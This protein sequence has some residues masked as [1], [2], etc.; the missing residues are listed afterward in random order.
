[1][2]PSQLEAWLQ[3]YPDKA[4]VVVVPVYNALEDVLECLESLKDTP[5]PILVIDD[6]SPHERV[7]QTL[8]QVPYVYYWRKEENSGFVGSVNLAFELTKP[9]DVVV[10]NSDVV[11][12]DGWLERL[13]RAAYSQPHVA[14]ATPLSNNGAVVSVPYRN[15]PVGD[16][17]GGLSLAELDRRVQKNSSRL[18]PALPTCI[19][20]C[21]YFKRIALDVAGYFDPVFAPGYGEEVDL[22]QRMAQAGFIHVAADDLFVYHKGSRSFGVNET[23][24]RLQQAHE[25]IVEERY[26]WY[27]AWVKET[28]EDESGPLARSLEAA[29][30]AALGY[31]FAIDASAI[32]GKTAGTQVATLELIA[33]L[34]RRLAGTPD[35]LSIILRDGVPV[36]ALQG[37][38]KAVSEVVYISELGDRKFDLVHR[39]GQVW[40]G[41]ELVWLQKASRRLVVTFLD[42]IFYATPAYADSVEQ[43]QEARQ[44]ARLTFSQAD[45]LIFISQNG[46]EDARQQGLIAPPERSRVTYLGVDHS[47]HQ[48]ETR[49][50]ARSEELAGE[51][52]LLVLGNDFGHKHRPFAIQL[53]AELVQKYGWKGRLVLAGA[54]M[55]KGGS[56]EAERTELA[57]LE[58]LARRVLDLGPVDEAGKQWLL[59]KAALL[60]YPSHYE[61]F[62]IVPFE[63][64]T[65]STPALAFAAGAVK[66]VLGY[67]LLYLENLNPQQAAPLAWQLLTDE[68]VRERQVNAL[69]Q[70][71]GMYTWEKVAASTLDFYHK[72]LNQPP[73][74][75]NLTSI[76]RFQAHTEEL[77]REYEKLK[78]WAGQLSERLSTLESRPGYR[79][80]SKLKML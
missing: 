78:E 23:K 62:G 24:Q 20:H 14:T 5:A 19:G 13:Q 11:L 33:A 40:A 76:E 42:A 36:E 67:E 50:L 74:R 53:F 9:R 34:A 27:T 48:A 68:E 31:S 22:A 12:P 54:K 39:T 66:E 56:S 6:A 29:R 44:L 47:L 4:P 43:W 60:L 1:M 37:L 32:D 51:P 21:T 7:E 57:H 71:A 2:D 46:L 69:K 70:R 8:S 45:G 73:R 80:L 65:A 10:V 72:T 63:A 64:A 3:K 58:G 77:E 18:Y 26:P 59:Q 35:R 61:G 30:G 41:E 17:P 52:Y 75:D 15:Q 49:P 79:I 25:A 55:R 16:L 38:D 28:T